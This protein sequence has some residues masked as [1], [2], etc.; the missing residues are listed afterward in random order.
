MVECPVR[1]N[2]NLLDEPEDLK[3]EE[4]SGN[5]VA[6]VS[7]DG[8][9]EISSIWS[10]EMPDE[11]DK[12]VDSFRRDRFEMQFIN[13]PFYF[14][15]GEILRDLRTGEY[16]VVATSKEDWNMFLENVANGL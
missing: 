9:G 11:E 7:L 16:G 8:N 1:F 2:P 5:A 6:A 3:M 14:K 4:Y 15:K 13:I 10:S 12:T